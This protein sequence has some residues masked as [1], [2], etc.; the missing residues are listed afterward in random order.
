VE[1]N[2]HGVHRVHGVNELVIDGGAVGAVFIVIKPARC[3]DIY[4]LYSPNSVYSVY[5][6]YSVSSVS[7]VSS[8]YS[9]V[10]FSR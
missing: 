9:V 8:V 7:S 3:A 6:V 5:S 10:I 4:F 1:K 2:N